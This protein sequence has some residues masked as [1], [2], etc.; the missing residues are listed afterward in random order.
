MPSNIVEYSASL[1]KLFPPDDPDTLWLLRLAILRDDLTHEVEHLGLTSDAAVK[2]FWRSTYAIRRLSL[3][4]GEV[5]NVFVNLVLKQHLHKLRPRSGDEFADR[6]EALIKRVD[7][8]YVLLEPIRNS[9]GGHVQP[10]NALGAQVPDPIPTVIRNF[11]GSPIALRLD[12]A[13]GM[14]TSLHELSTHAL[15]FIWPDVT[16]FDKM[17]KRHKQLSVTLFECVTSIMHGIDAILF[18]HFQKVGVQSS[19]PLE[20]PAAP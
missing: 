7:E 5:N 16:N 8:G 2:D 3:I 4:V 11:G 1:D 12:K 9:L 13:T 17:E 20:P 15:F 10:K 19:T 6:L 18:M 14:G